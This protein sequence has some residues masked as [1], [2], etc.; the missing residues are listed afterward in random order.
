MPIW[1]A[2][3]AASP[4]MMYACVPSEKSVAQTTNPIASGPAFSWTHLESP[5]RCEADSGSE[6]P[7]MKPA[8]HASAW[9]ES[10]SE[11]RNSTCP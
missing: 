1:P 5:L 8:T 11:L 6:L 2:S 3:A 7:A 9:R 10:T 4:P